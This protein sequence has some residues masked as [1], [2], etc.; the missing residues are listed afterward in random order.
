MAGGD[1]GALQLSGVCASAA[2]ESWAAV[3]YRQIHDCV[4]YPYLHS[5]PAEPREE[6]GDGKETKEDRIRFVGRASRQRL[7]AFRVEE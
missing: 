6:Q 7:D 1:V 5:R 2:P 4:A 3:S